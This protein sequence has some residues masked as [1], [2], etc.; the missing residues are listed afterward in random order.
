MKIRNPLVK[1]V[2]YVNAIPSAG[3]SWKLKRQINNGEIKS[4]ILISLPTAKLI[5]EYSQGITASVHTILS[6][7]SELSVVQ[8][9]KAALAPDFHL[10]VI[11]CTHEC[12]KLY[13]QQAALEDLMQLPLRSVAI[14]V[15]EC[16]DGAFGAQVRVQHEDFAQDNYP[17]LQW[18]TPHEKGGLF[19]NEAYREQMQRYYEESHAKSDDMNRIIWCLL[20]GYALLAEE[21]KAGFWYTAEATNPLILASQWAASFTI[22]AAGVDK[23]E[24]LYRA[25]HQLGFP[26]IKAPAGFQPDASR[27][28][29]KRTNQ[30]KISYVFD[31][32]ASMTRLADVFTDV[33]NWIR[34]NFREGFLYATNND[35]TLKGEQVNFT[36]LADQE[37]SGAGERI[38]MSAFG[39]NAYAG[40][41][42]CGM[43]EK[44]LAKA[45]VVHT[46]AAYAGYTQCVYLGIVND[47]PFHYQRRQ[48]YADCMGWD[49]E[50][51]DTRRHLQ[52]NAERCLQTLARTVIR[53]H[54]NLKPVHFLVPDKDTAEYLQANYFPR[55]ELN[56]LN[57]D[58]DTK[59]DTTKADVRTLFNKGL[60]QVQIAAQTGLSKGRVSQLV[61]QIKKEAA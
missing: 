21:D 49:F 23:S 6:D 34:R 18:L 33:L 50:Q 41:N 5:E 52:Q 27:A 51:L 22:M 24:L 40:F 3:K 12:L 31:R 7:D 26:V 44:R 38:S 56:P 61:S 11:I 46:A 15:D 42:V 60:K 57:Y 55:C 8:Q 35:K 54:D 47:E 4:K 45:G 16:P 36:R 25:E 43:D 10:Q 53:D 14:F 59:G 9:L 19:L 1:P 2:Y 29:F 30:I 32:S 13:C 20:R 58:Q 28:T 37:L 48:R 39:L 17:F